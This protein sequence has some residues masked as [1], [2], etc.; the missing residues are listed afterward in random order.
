MLISI[1]S[2]FIPLLFK[3]KL[4][5]SEKKV[6]YL[7]ATRFL[8]R[9]KGNKSYEVKYKQNRIKIIEGKTENGKRRWGIVE[10]NEN[11]E[12]EIG[13]LFLVSSAKETLSRGITE[14][15]VKYDTVIY[16]VNKPFMHQKNY[17]ELKNES[18]KII[19]KHQEQDILRWRRDI[20]VEEETLN[21]RDIAVCVLVLSLIIFIS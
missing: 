14:Y 17:C 6:G 12:K 5:E 13:S 16:H 20:K 7:K 8:G 18:N 3:Q 19:A 21:E 2:P 4:V 15:E 1:K 9:I 11:E 10:L